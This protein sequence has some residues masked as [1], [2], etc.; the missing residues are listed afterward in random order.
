V[1]LPRFGVDTA[2]WISWFERNPRFES[3]LAGLLA[4]VILGEALAVVSTLAILE[5]LTG[6]YRR[7]DEKLADRYREL[8][9]NTAGVVVVPLDSVI[10]S[11]AARIRVRYHIT[12]PDAIHLATA[13]VSGAPA[14]L[15]TDRRL[16]RVREIDVKV[17]RPLRVKR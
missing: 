8:F 6:A 10:A 17:V 16:S 7:R 12:T 3:T 15:T 13:L 2:I 5:V 9:L 11:E 14:F 1:T 4:G